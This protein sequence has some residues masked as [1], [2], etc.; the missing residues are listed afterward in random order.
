MEPADLKD[1]TADELRTIIVEMD[2]DMTVLCWKK[3]R[4]DETSLKRML[5]KGNVDEARAA[6]CEMLLAIN[7]VTNA[8]ERLTK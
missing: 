3:T 6:H 5:G 8:W 1:K 4:Y 2:G 7:G